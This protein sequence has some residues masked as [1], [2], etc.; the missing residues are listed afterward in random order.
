MERARRQPAGYQLQAIAQANRRIQ[1]G[2]EIPAETLRNKIRGG[3]LGQILGNLNGLPHE[4]KSIAEPGDVIQYVP[5]LPEG[6]WTDDD[7]DFEWVYIKVME[8][9]NCLL[10]PHEKICGSRRAR[11]CNRDVNKRRNCHEHLF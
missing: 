6:A 9:E 5:G 10:L 8:D 4:F 3:L 11:R 7:T 2:R 1:R